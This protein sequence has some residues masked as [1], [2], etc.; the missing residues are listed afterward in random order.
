MACP[1][2]TY[3]GDKSWGIAAQATMW[4][5]PKQSSPAPLAAGPFPS[6]WCQTAQGPPPTSYCTTVCYS[7][8]LYSTVVLQNSE[9]VFNLFRFHACMFNKLK[10]I[11][12]LLHF[13]N[14]FFLYWPNLRK[15]YCRLKNNN[16]PLIQRVQRIIDLAL[17]WR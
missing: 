3:Y 17:I 7:L 5:S 13:G 11:R 15:D 2:S 10:G 9:I 4:S 14:F 8:L 12:Y 1:Q 16:I 6:L